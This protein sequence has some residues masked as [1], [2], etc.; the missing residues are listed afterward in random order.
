MHKIIF[1]CL[2]LLLSSIAFSQIQYEEGYYIDNSGNKISGFI[3]NND[4]NDNPVSF[5]F[6]AAMDSEIQVKTFDGVLEFGL[7]NIR[8]TKF[9]V[10]IDLSR[11]RVRELTSQRAPLFTQKVVFLK[12]IQDGKADLFIYQDNSVL[13]YF[14]RLDEDS[15]KQLVY[16]KF[17]QGGK[18]AVNNHYQQQLFN[19]LNCENNT[20]SNISNVSYNRIDLERYFTKYNNCKNWSTSYY[21]NNSSGKFNLKV[22]LGA[23]FT[24]MEIDNGLNAGGESFN[25]EF[26]I[27]A[28]AELEYIMPF[29]RNKWSVFI[30]P[31]YRSFKAERNLTKSYNADFSISNQSIELAL[32]LRHYLFLN[33]S[34]KLFINVL[35]SSDLPLKTE[36]SFMNTNM[37]EDPFLDEFKSGAS[38]GI[39]VGMQIYNRLAMELR[40]N[41]S[42]ELNGSKFVDKTYALNFESSYNTASVILTYSLL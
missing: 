34:T 27:R 29:N 23:D 39:G 33:T 16:K 21:D 8:F 28:G 3:E 5:N 35:V 7:E 22:L 15:P 1:T 6:K 30:Q 9:K 26:F 32:G 19:D 18:I 17:L 10:Q 42:R 24:G 14:Y 12:Y 38:F 20:S 36:V 13:R 4:W 37:V 41:S 2:S 25:N 40:Y 31:V 11:D